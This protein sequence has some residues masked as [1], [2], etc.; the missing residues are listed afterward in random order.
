MSS[1]D[2]EMALQCA[3]SCLEGDSCKCRSRR[4]RLVNHHIASSAHEMTTA[5]AN[6]FAK[7]DDCIIAEE[8]DD[9]RS[10]TPRPIV[11]M[12][13]VQVVSTN[14]IL[15]ALE[16]KS[17]TDLNVVAKKTIDLLSA[18]RVC[19]PRATGVCHGLGCEPCT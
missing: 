18:T 7:S 16:H 6:G 12:Q 8:T 4:I 14:D 3:V 13:T 1:V 11:E 15:G 17:R 9:D 5:K 19:S 10:R 2:H